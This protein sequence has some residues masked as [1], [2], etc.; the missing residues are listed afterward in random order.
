MLF[1]RLL[2][3]ILVG[4]ALSD[5]SQAAQT[6]A[7]PKISSLPTN[8]SQILDPRLASFSMEFSYLPTFGG[9]KTHPNLL[10]KELMQRL[11]ERTGL[12][13]DIRPGGITIDSSIYQANATALELDMSP[14]GGIYRTTYGPAWFES[15]DVFPN[16]SQIV[17]TVNLA[18]DTIDIARDQLA[19][20][21]KTIGW[22]RIRALELGNE[23][24]HYAGAQRPSTWGSADYTAQYLGWTTFLS[25]NLSLPSH[26]FQAAGFVDF[27]SVKEVIGEGITDT[28]TVKVFSQHTY[29]YSTCDP[30]RNAIA[31][32]PNLVNHGNITAFL[33]QWKPQI[34]AAKQVG[35]EFVVGEYNSVSC[36]GKENVTNTFGQALWLADTVLYGATLDIS[37]LYLH[38]GAT[39]VLQSST[40][41]NTP[42]FSWYDQWYP[43]SSDRFGDPHAGPS[44]VA[45]LLITEAVGSSQ[46]SQIALIPTPAFPQLV[47]YA[48]W[49]PISRP[50]RDGPARIAILNLATR[51]VTASARETDEGSAV[52]DLASGASPW[53]GVSY[54]IVTLF[55]SLMFILGLVYPRSHLDFGVG[56]GNKKF[57]FP[58]FD[59]IT[60]TRTLSDQHIDLNSN[61]RIILIGDIHGM[62]DSLSDLLSKLSYNQ[63]NDI[64]MFAGDLL[65]KSTHSGSL[66]L[67][68]FLTANHF[69]STPTNQSERIF[70]I[71][72][73][74]DQ[75]VIQWRS[76]REWFE[77]QVIPVPA[78]SRESKEDVVTDGKSFIELIEA[79]W[80]MERKR[81][82]SDAEEWVHVSRKRAQGTWREEWWRRIP[83]SGTGKK[84]KDWKIF[85]DHYWLA[86]DMTA[87]HTSFL[88]AL[89]LVNHVPSL[90]MF[91]VHAGLLPYNPR[92]P[93]N[94]P[95]Q[96]L[97]HPPRMAHASP[98]EPATPDNDVVDQISDNVDLTPD[99]QYILER[100]DIED[101]LRQEQ[102]KAILSDI[103]QNK[104]PWVVLNMR[105]VKKNGKITRKNDKGTPWSKLWN[106]QMKQCSGLP[107][108]EVHSADN[109]TEFPCEPSTVIYG[110]A[111]TRGLDIKRYSMGLDTGC[112]YGQRL[113]A[114][115][116]SRGKGGEVE[117]G[118]DE[119]ENG[120]EDGGDDEPEDTR[121]G[122]VGR[123]PR[124]SYAGLG[125]RQNNNK[126]VK[127]GDAAMQLD[128]RLVQIKCSLPPESDPYDH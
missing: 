44:F 50:S 42:G 82:E 10:T 38:Q 78:G 70:A 23:P 66:S 96:P 75:L 84:A 115:V 101:D 31:T 109:D 62:N 94:D 127:F 13:P 40:Q 5:V 2:N 121:D 55:I 15:L 92:L 24:D 49:D 26:I 79:E 54:A 120:D 32:L 64:L 63:R 46:K 68:D 33:D 37:R 100:R 118:E 25:R 113:T 117:D 11:V 122:E 51:N 114:L 65:A 103:P 9:N 41:A 73:N 47:V 69:A 98:I 61:D 105:G 7:L 36:S 125:R 81:R 83:P 45:L 48:I 97:A 39:L 3:A 14:S 28:N 128:A 88:N 16:S 89:P 80:A 123:R 43:A 126:K 30:T 107:S 86:R 95:R 18:N 124:R 106:G 17:V 116:V 59:V 20:H 67:L 99:G 93:I 76:W 102:E 1:L 6:V 74:H 112:L 12:G 72:G 108:S 52:L 77:R 110:H 91:V 56:K 60:H 53:T 8:A 21:T 119:D 35:A 4:F 29:Q 57:D 58:D 22:N 34:A 111:A 19:V 85:G 104:D 71:R 27:W 90:H 87:E